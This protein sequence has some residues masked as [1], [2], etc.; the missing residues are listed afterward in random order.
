MADSGYSGE[1][2]RVEIRG[3]AFRVCIPRQTLMLMDS[4]KGIEWKQSWKEYDFNPHARK[5]ESEDKEEEM[6]NG[7]NDMES[8]DERDMSDAMSYAQSVEVRSYRL[9]RLDG[10]STGDAFSIHHFYSNQ[11]VVSSYLRGPSFYVEDAVPRGNKMRLL[12]LQETNVCIV[13]DRVVVIIMDGSQDSKGEAAGL[14]MSRFQLP[15]Y[16]TSIEGN[17]PLKSLDNDDLDCDK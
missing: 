7:S 6:S 10:D 13:Y 11:M 4:E 14:L 15:S 1:L 16:S 12:R 3:D 5:D 2:E 8:Q 17:Y 9:D